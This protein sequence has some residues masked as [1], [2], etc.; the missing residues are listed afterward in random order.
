MGGLSCAPAR[1]AG[2]SRILSFRRSLGSQGLRGH[3]GAQA[4]GDQPLGQCCAVCSAV[5]SPVLVEG[6]ALGGAS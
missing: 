2:R 6:T 4:M 3:G 1:T 5:V